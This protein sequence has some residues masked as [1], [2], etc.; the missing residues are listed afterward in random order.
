AMGGRPDA[1]VVGN[2]AE[3][4]YINASCDF[5]IIQES[6]QRLEAHELDDKEDF[7]LRRSIR[8]DGRSKAFINGQPCPLSQLKEL[9]GLLMDIHS[10]HQH[11]SLLRKDTHRKLLDEFAGAEHL[12]DQA[13][14]AW[15]AWN[16]TRQK[17]EQRRH[18][19]DEAEA[20]LQLLRYQVEELDRLALEDGEQEAL[21]Q[22]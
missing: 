4:S 22:E 16:A 2:V 3:R 13:R 9:G 8:K 21:E 6:R 7:I 11:Q 5:S 1:G 15:K 18:N 20:R 14:S 19:A 17:L 12:A 10:Q